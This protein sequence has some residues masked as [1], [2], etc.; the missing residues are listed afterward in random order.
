D[1][2]RQLQY[3]PFQGDAPDTPTRSSDLGRPPR[4]G[5]AQADAGRT[6]P[7]RRRLF[8]AVWDAFTLASRRRFRVL[9]FSV[10]A[11]HL[12]L[13]GE[14]DAPTGLTRRLQGL[15]I[16]VVK[17]VSRALGRHETVWSDTEPRPR[18]RNA[19]RGPKRNGNDRSR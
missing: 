7:P 14:A 13:V 9:R 18:A 4:P 2:S 5:R 10:Q 6:V 17:A 12:R 3:M 1:G 8:A 11:D 16:R 19:A 15:A